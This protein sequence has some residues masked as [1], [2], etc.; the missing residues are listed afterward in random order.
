M[1]RVSFRERNDRNH[2]NSDLG[3]F[4]RNPEQ[5]SN[6]ESKLNRLVSD[7]TSLRKKPSRHLHTA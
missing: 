3:R 5:F 1:G 2:N 6:W 7:W 4:I